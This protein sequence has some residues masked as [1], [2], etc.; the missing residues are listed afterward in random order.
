MPKPKRRTTSSALLGDAPARSSLI[1]DGGA[2]VDVTFA[3][4]VATASV[5]VTLK[6]D[7]MRGEGCEE[8]RELAS[9]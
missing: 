1:I 3:D 6:D 5:K 7:A 9:S 4:N 8:L 2:A